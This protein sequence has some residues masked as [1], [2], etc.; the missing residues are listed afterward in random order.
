M[1]STA[2]GQTH[3]PAKNL[4]LGILAGMILT[5]GWI[6][7]GSFGFAN[8][9]QVLIDLF[10]DKVAKIFGKQH[11]VEFV[12]K[13]NGVKIVEVNNKKISEKL[14]KLIKPSGTKQI[15]SFFF[16]LDSD[17]L[18]EILRVIFSCDGC[19][20]LGVKW[21]KREKRWK[22]T[23]KV[24]LTSWNSEIKNGISRLLRKLE[25]NCNIE[26][27]GAVIERKCEI[28]KFNEKIGFLDGVKISGKSKNWEG[29][30]KNQILDLTIKTFNLKKRDL[31]QFKTKEEVIN[32]LKALI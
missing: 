29:L 19:V 23:R 31:A 21:N 25:I 24:K 6:N 4:E 8:I 9:S 12:D 13:R 17:S 14:L 10:K 5:D 16:T 26:A 22:F 2:S 28:K 27:T 30:E 32:F 3:T 7:R 15:P 20:C 18:R 11:F 1:P